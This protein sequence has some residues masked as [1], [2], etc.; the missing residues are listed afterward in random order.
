MKIKLFSVYDT[1]L[2]SF[3]FPFFMLTS[4]AAIR[5]FMETANDGKSEISKYPSDFTLFEH[6]CF[7]DETGK[8]ETLLTPN[9]LGV[10]STFKQTNEGGK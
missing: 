10:A 4:G 6:G 5:G 7:D 8:F 3:R 1:K 9:N 2:A